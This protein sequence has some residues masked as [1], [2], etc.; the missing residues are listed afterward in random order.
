[1]DRLLISCL[2]A[3]SMWMYMIQLFGIDWVILGS[4]V[5]LLC[6]WHH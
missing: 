3:H 4:V 1:M 2:L 5:D 6:C